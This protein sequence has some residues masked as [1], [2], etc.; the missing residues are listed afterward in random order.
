[1]AV[2]VITL[3]CLL[4][5]IAMRW[6]KNYAA[7]VAAGQQANTRTLC[8]ALLQLKHKEFIFIRDTLWALGFTL[9]SACLLLINADWY[10]LLLAN[11]LLLLALIDYCSGLLPDALTLPLMFTAWLYS[12]LGLVNASSASALLACMLYVAASL[13]FILRKRHGFGWGDIK[14]MSAIAGWYGLQIS[15]EILLSASMLALG[16]LLLIRTQTGGYFVFGPFIAI[17]TIAQMLI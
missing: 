10:L 14:L 3:S 4:G 16:S 8:I 9:P 5:I 6:A 7:A 12:P 13:Y 1:M 15:L 17:A 11:I 2:M